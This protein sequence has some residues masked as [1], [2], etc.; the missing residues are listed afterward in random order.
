VTVEYVIPG[1]ERWVRA[2]DGQ[3]L[4]SHAWGEGQ[5]IV[6]CNGIGVS[7]GFW[8]YIQR[9]FQASHKVILWDYRG[10]GRSPLPEDFS[11]MTISRMARDLEA[12]LEAHEVDR[13][14]LVG[15]SMGSQVILEHY[16]HFPNRAAALVP[17][18][19]TY[20]KPV[21][22]FFG[23]PILGHLFPVLH[24]LAQRAWRFIQGATRWGARSPLAFPVARRLGILNPSLCKAED[25]APYLEHLAT[26]DMRVFLA[27]AGDMA[28]HSAESLLAHIRAPVLIIGGEQDV[29]TPV[30]LSHEMH[31]L[32]PGSELLILPGGSHAGLVEQPELINLRIEKFL[33]ERV[34]THAVAE[35]HESEI[36][37]TMSESRTYR[38]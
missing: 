29:F 23:T 30:A 32:I 1:A 6:C 13:A 14:V 37:G 10:H 22:T 2:D 7:T 8:R 19:G 12:V 21:D 17:V 27:L 16:R 20:G 38:K 25:M 9:Y 3:R 4:Y 5:A 28:R 15:H 31:E 11:L 35:S 36:L 18:L 26:L 34:T 33:R 24:P